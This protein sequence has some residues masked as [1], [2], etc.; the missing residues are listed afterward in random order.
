MVVLTAGTY[1]GRSLTANRCKYHRWK[2]DSRVY[3][4][5]GRRHQCRN[6]QPRGVAVDSSGNVYI[7]DS[8]YSI[9]RVVS[10]TTAIIS[11]SA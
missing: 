9:I 1:F 6:D 11:V 5:W 10:N 4:G 7:A 2:R 8:A 3:G